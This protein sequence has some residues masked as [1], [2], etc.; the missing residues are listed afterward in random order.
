M[1]LALVFAVQKLRHYM[2]AHTIYLVTKD[3]PVRYL[4][5][6]SAMSGRKARWLLLLSQFDIV[7]TRKRPVKGQAIADLLAERAIPATGPFDVTLPDEHI[8]A[9]EDTPAWIM[10]FDRLAATGNG[11]MGLK[12]WH[13]LNVNCG[14]LARWNALKW[15]KG[16]SIGGSAVVFRL[17]ARGPSNIRPWL[18][19]IP[20]LWGSTAIVSCCSCPRSCCYTG[21]LSLNLSGDYWGL[22]LTATSTIPVCWRGK[23]SWLW[24]RWS[25]LVCPRGV[26]SARGRS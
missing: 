26:Q 12:K 11:G 13:Q 21:P 8:L 7:C 20:N 25:R 17:Q 5:N 6:Q 10:H 19:M 2:L 22:S 23:I 16:M 4:L 3:N 1:Y 18:L 9:V 15:W 24:F 14:I